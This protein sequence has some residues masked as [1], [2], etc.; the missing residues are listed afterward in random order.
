[1]GSSCARA[2]QSSHSI[3]YDVACPSVVA[4]EPETVGVEAAAG[5]TPLPL[6]S[7][8][9]ELLI[10]RRQLSRAA[11]EERAALLQLL[12]VLAEELES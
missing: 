2:P 5:T 10:R 8:G 7:D 1:M 9:Q 6:F 3:E 11:P 12:T 4:A